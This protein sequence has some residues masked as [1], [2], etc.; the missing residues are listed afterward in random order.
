MA[1]KREQE[2]RNFV[3]LAEGTKRWV[4]SAG[5]VD[6]NRLFYEL[7]QNPLVPQIYRDAINKVIERARREGFV[8]GVKEGLDGG[9][10]L[11]EELR[12][13]A[14][15]PENVQAVSSAM[16]KWQMSKGGVS[17]EDRSFWDLLEIAGRVRARSQQD[18]APDGKSLEFY[19]QRTSAEE[20]RSIARAER[21]VF[22]I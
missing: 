13:R 14:T 7:M 18:L 16:Y 12:A 11:Y 5:D 20:R 19:E 17:Q 1:E 21:E 15:S 6:A 22:G 9:Q 3:E 4:A 10:P 2:L 8:N